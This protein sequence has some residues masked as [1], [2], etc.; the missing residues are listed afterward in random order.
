MRTTKRTAVQEGYEHSQP[1]EPIDARQLH[2]FS[3]WLQLVRAYNFM[4]AR[5]SADL[6]GD[7]LTLAQFDALV[8]LVKK[9]AIS[10]Q[11]LAD[12]LLVTKGNVVGLID[13]LSARGFVER[14]GS[15][16][17]RRVNLLQITPR[18]RR[19]VERALPRQLQ[20][21]SCLMTTLTS[22]EAATLEDL[23]SRVRG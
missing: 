11:E 2:G 1:A 19:V 4:E 8:A 7:D 23:L 17:D 5:I 18:G 16:T 12:H 14:R 20:L 13:R 22:E 21:I 9:G 15:D 6:R 10:Q 3:A